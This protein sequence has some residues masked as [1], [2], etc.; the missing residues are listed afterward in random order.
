ME[1][2]KQ[3]VALLYRLKG[4][5][6]MSESDFVMSA[7]MGLRWF[8]PTDAQRFLDL[9]LRS[10]LLARSNREL[11]PSFNVEELDIPPEFKPS[12]DIL[13]VS[14]PVEEDLFS[15]IIGKLSAAGEKK[16]IVARVNAV[17]Q[18]YGIELEVAAL[19][20][21]NDMGIDVK[22]FVPEV[23]EILRKRARAD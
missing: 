6:S 7:S 16:D 12:K 5:R 1:K 10:K 3:A 2:L 22:E 13:N 19:L 17:Q 18:K 23:E 20:T 11:V 21:G 9:A 15:R 8:E 4:K 14:I